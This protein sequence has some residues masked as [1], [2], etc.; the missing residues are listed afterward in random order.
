MKHVNQQFPLKVSVI[1]NLKR[2]VG[3]RNVLTSPE[4]LYVYSREHLFREQVYPK[5]DA[6]VKIESEQ[7]KNEVEKLAEKMGLQV[8]VRGEEKEAAKLVF[9]TILLDDSEPPQLKPFLTQPTEMNKILEEIHRSGHGTVRNF[10]LALKFLFM[11]ETPQKCLQCK[12]CSGYC[13]VAASFNNVETWSSKGRILLAKALNKKELP[14]TE[15][16]VDVFYTCSTCGLC[17]AQCFP[18]LHVNEVIIATRRYIAEKHGAPQTFVSTAKNIL[19]TGNPSGLSPNQRLSWI[20]ET[21]KQNF[22]PEADVLLWIGCMVATRTPKTAKAIVNILN[23]A[24]TCFTMLGEKE[25]CCGYVL[26]TSGLWKEAE[27]LAKRVIEEVKDTKAEILVT[28]CAG[29]YYTFN[30]LYPKIL[31]MEIPCETIHST[32]LLERLIKD[33]TIKLNTL[34]AKI[35]YHDPCS[36]GRH[37]NVYEAPRKVLEAIPYAQ[38]VEMPL[39]K[40]FARCCGGGGGL[41]TFKTQVSMDSAY[42]RLKEDV[43]PLGVDMLATA[44][45][46]CNMNLRYTSKRKFIGIKVCDVMEIVEQALSQ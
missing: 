26:L 13:T 39:N 28:P 23:K 16:L 36:L 15:K 1:E 42:V 5:I 20:K 45:P 10:A 21:T 29:C 43:A 32:Q 40:S 2:I 25:E 34:N 46:A 11:R 37:G 24:K 22:P 30:T 18:D 9:G 31:G 17:F 19:E 3:S 12:I 33:D 44:C 38:L 6:V 35:T 7:Q 14:L 27:K 4:D 8:I 41:L